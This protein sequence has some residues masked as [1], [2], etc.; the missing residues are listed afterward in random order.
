MTVSTTEKM[1]RLAHARPDL[2]QK[3]LPMIA[4]AK[5][6]A[7]ER[8][9]LLQVGNGFE[10]E[11]RM[12]RFH[13]YMDSLRVTDLTN[14]GKRGKKVKQ[15]VVTG[16]QL[17]KGIE[18]EMVDQVTRASSFK[19]ALKKA[20]DW[21]DAVSENASYVHLYESEDRGVDVT[22]AG[23]KP[24]SVD[25]KYVYIDAEYKTF[26]I[27]DKE[28][29]YNLPTCIPAIKGG[30]KDIKVFYR[31]VKDNQTKLKGMKFR[32]VVRALMSEGIKFHQYCAMD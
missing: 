26:R 17:T 10:D 27:R 18:N 30:K 23:F 14:A 12:L 13:R 4:R 8:V 29:Q 11:R 24:I 25:G 20:K 2:R 16:L 32:E 22:P 1:I 9:A 5:R 6:E 7:A 21:V 19:D 28:D 15:F 3:I 31:W